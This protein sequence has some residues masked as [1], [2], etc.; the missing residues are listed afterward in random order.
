ME[1]VTLSPI[2]LL[3]GTGMVVVALGFIVYALVRRLGWGY[4]GLGALAWIITVAVKFLWALPVNPRLYPAITQALPGAPGAALFDLYVGLLTGF[5]EVAI[6]W[7]VM[8]Y[9]RLSRVPWQR[10]LAFGI[11]FGTIEALLLGL[12][13]L[14]SALTALLAPQA[15]PA[16]AL[17]QLAVMNNILYGIAPIVER[18][19]TVWVHIFCSV[20]IFFS[21]AKMQV[22]WFWLSFL[23]KSLIDAVASFAQTSGLIRS[24]EGIWAIEAIVVLFG[25]I[26]WLGVR[27][28]AQRYPAPSSEQRSRQR[29]GAELATAGFLVLVILSMTAGAVGAVALQNTTLTGSARDA[30]LAYTEPKTTNLLTAIDNRDYAA[31]SR[32]L[33]D[34]MKSAITADGLIAMRSKVSDKI[35]R[36][37][38]REVTSVTPSGNFITVIYAARFENDDPVTVRVSFEA[39]EPHRISGLFFDS[40]KLR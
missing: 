18:F 19:S 11:G 6:V 22:R 28:L 33:D 17:A 34:K 20:L 15:L 38:S 7:L 1:T 36:Y 24:A 37:I 31:F 30:V 13:S 21:V 5:T 8:R 39:A 3:G 9:T 32:D 14:A 29:V 2:A 10:A 26:G 40:A 35:G 25:I 27:W 12:G 4:L 16:Q 23:F